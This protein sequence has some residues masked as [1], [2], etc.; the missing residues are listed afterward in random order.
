[1]KDSVSLKIE[2]K[3]FVNQFTKLHRL[4]EKA[5]KIREINLKQLNTFKLT[6][7]KLLLGLPNVI[8]NLI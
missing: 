3:Q 4:N 6:N 7:P 2:I 1:M 8:A 5:I